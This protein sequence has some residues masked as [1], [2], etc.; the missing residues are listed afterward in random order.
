MRFTK[1]SRKKVS[2][3]ETRINGVE[4]LLTAVARLSLLLGSGLVCLGADLN[5][6]ALKA[7]L[8][9]Q[10]GIKTMPLLF[11]VTRKLRDELSNEERAQVMKAANEEARAVKVA[12]PLLVTFAELEAAVR[13]KEMATA[14]K[15][16]LLLQ[17]FFTKTL[18]ANPPDR[19]RE[20]RLAQEAVDREPSYLNFYR[21]AISAGGTGRH[22]IAIEASQ[23][24]IGLLSKDPVMGSRAD[25]FHALHNI[26]TISLWEEGR[27]DLAAKA[28]LESLDFGNKRIVRWCPDIFAAEK[29]WKGGEHAAVT[30]Y[31]EKAVKVGFPACESSIK[32]WLAAINAGQAPDFKLPP[33]P[34][35]N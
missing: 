25:P 5:L 8:E 16:A 35:R 18:L 1:G 10:E 2:S 13:A 28:L 6:D 26:L 15:Q 24:A 20:F 31:F 19:E 12:P 11:E 29:M 9:K 21:L 4:R 34:A 23:N 32:T 22:A 30:A 33:P 14:Y 27:R 3:L 17:Q 7:S